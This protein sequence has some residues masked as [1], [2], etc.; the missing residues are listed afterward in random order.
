MP[1]WIMILLGALP[2][3]ISMVEGLFGG[4]TGPEKKATVLEIVTSILSLVTTMSTGAQA[5]LWKA[6]LPLIPPIIDAIATALFPKGT[7]V[8]PAEAVKMSA[9][10]MRGDFS[11]LERGTPSFVDTITKVTP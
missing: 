3:V 9:Q 1:I 11:A 8:T 5:A 4:G 7:T 6:L 10:F 2:A